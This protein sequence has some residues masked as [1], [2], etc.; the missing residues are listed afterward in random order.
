MSL[1]K[2]QVKVATVLE[3]GAEL[4][5]KLNG[6]EAEMYRRE[7]GHRSL[8]EA[9][10]RARSVPAILMKEFKENGA[11]TLPGGKKVELTQETVEVIHFYLQR[12]FYCLESLAAADQASQLIERGKFNA[13]TEFYETLLRMK[14]EQQAKVD[15]AEKAQSLG[16][17]PEEALRPRPSGD[18]EER[19]LEA[20]RKRE[21]GQAA[22]VPAPVG[23]EERPEEKLVEVAAPVVEAAPPSSPPEVVSPPVGKPRRQRGNHAANA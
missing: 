8:T 14:N 15:L 18:L 20:L 12:V 21:E 22:V 16:I 3:V 17:D 1:L 11:V 23:E 13:L 9:G 7:G 6:A 2:A 4:E 19:R 10:Q 5:K